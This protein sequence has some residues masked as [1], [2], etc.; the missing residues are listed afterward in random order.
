MP[1]AVDF[2]ISDVSG[3]PVLTGMTSGDKTG[4]EVGHLPAGFYVFQTSLGAKK[5]VKI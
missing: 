2:T 5:W 4:I 3:K 1:E